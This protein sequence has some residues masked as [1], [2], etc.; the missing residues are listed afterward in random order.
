MDRLTLVIIGGL[1]LHG[2]TTLGKDL[3]KEIGIHLADIDPLRREAFGFPTREEYESRWADQEAG[4]KWSSSRMRMA[5]TLLHDGAVDIALG[6]GQSLMVASTY[7][8]AISQKF[9][10]GFAEKYGAVVRPIICRL[11]N[12]TREEIERRMERDADE[13]YIHGCATWNDYL[14]ITERFE[15]LDTAGVF[16]PESVLVVDTTTPVTG[17]AFDRVVEF[18]S[19]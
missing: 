1:P 2:K 5:Y 11:A 18:I 13:E 10:K 6:A 17:K 16:P 19:S 12:E 15:A 3:E 4:A 14:D 8:R 9:V 7:S